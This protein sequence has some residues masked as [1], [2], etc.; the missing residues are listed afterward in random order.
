MTNQVKFRSGKRL[1]RDWQGLQD[2]TTASAKGA[3]VPCGLF[4]P[5]V[6]LSKGQGG[7]GRFSIFW[8]SVKS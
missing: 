8:R 7:A 2:Q 4:T 1:R 3:A 5:C 6:I